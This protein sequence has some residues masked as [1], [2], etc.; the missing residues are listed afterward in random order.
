MGTKSGTKGSPS[1]G[2]WAPTQGQGQA[3]PGL[4]YSPQVGLAWQGSCC[5]ELETSPAVVSLGQG[6]RALGS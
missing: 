3:E 1:P 4:G 5:G 6:L 2:H